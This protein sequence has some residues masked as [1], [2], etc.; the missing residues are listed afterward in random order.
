[1]NVEVVN[2]GT[3]LMLGSVLNTHLS[4]LAKALFPLGLRVSRQVTV[5]D[6]DAIREVLVEAL[7]RS[8]IVVITGGL[9]PT[10]DDITRDIVAKLLGRPLKHDPDVMRTIKSFFAGRNLTITERVSRQAQVPEGAL[11]LPNHFGTAPGLYIECPTSALTGNHPAHLFLLPGPPR[12]LQPMFENA[13]IPILEQ[14]VPHR[15]DQSCRTYHVLGVGESNVEALV[16]SQLGRIKGLELG[17]CARPGEVDVRCIGSQSVLDAAEKIV[18]D[19]L[20]DRIASLDGRSLEQVVVEILHQ[21]QQTL[22]T[23][24]SCTGGALANTITDVP[25]SSAV[26]LAGFIT[27]A[28]EAKILD[29][30]V[31]PLLIEN[32]GAVSAQVASAMAEGALHRSGS[33][34]ALSTTGIAG[35]TGGTLEKPQGT[36]FIALAH[37]ETPTR[38]EKHCFN[39]DR[40]VFKDLVTQTAMDILRRTLA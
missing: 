24:E 15:K 17:Y 21:R 29:L 16:G 19:A 28:N 38:V 25:G 32:H 27:Y 12:E 8:E 30:G 13:A 36:V 35:P 34:W 2:T 9:G 6:G 5:P 39:R 23:A 11:V 18:M 20:G 40:K 10:T 7:H 1:M 26:F 31:N 4:Y 14:V 3:E 33:D 37:R 22:S